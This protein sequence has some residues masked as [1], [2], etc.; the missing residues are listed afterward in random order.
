MCRKKIERGKEREGD[1]EA[2]CDGSKKI[3]IFLI[4]QRILR[5]EEE[6]IILKRASAGD[7][8]MDDDKSD[9]KE[10]KAERERKNSTRETFFYLTTGMQSE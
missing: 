7:S 2:C 6:I 3:G 8:K 1:T 4:S 10:S 5:D 9:F